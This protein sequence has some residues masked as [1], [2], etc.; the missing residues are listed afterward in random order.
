[1][2]VDV[3]VGLQ[4]GDEGK[5]KIVDIL[6]PNYKIIARYQGGPN[7]GHTLVIKGKKYVF[8]TLPSGVIHENAINVLGSGMVIDPIVLKEEI[9]KLQ[10]ENISLEGRLLI[11]KNLHLILPTHKL[12]DAW[13]EKLNESKKIGSTLKGIG[14]SYQDKY[15]RRGIRSRDIFSSRFD[16]KYKDLKEFHL[17]IMSSYDNDH[18]TEIENK[19][20]EAVDYMKTLEI[21]DAEQYLNDE[22]ENGTFILA[23]GAQGTLL[24]VNFGSYPYVTSSNTISSSSCVGLGIAPQHIRYTYGVFKAYTTRVGEGPFLTEQ[25][26]EI[27][28]KLM[29]TGFE[30]GSTTGRPRRCGW[31]D[32]VA[33]KYACMLNGVN[34]LII[35]KSDVLNCIDTINIC[36]DYQDQNGKNILFGDHEDLVNLKLKY[37]EFS[38]WTTDISSILDYNKLP[39][40]FKHYLEFIESKL[41]KKIDIVSVGPDRKQTILR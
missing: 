35:T 16:E 23:E 18:L 9:E 5:G 32:L 15:G 27:G 31:L 14:P 2:P 40:T 39:E 24:D 22:L 36:T 37:Q 11:S 4:W 26:N 34:K 28:K 1:M 12:L 21:I 33:L 19:W 6:A 29:E 20:F 25:I 38:S 30:Y 3:I 13:F 8:H 41:G 10:K 17:N 7:A